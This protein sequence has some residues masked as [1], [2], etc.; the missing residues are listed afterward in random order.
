MIAW[1][2]LCLTPA[3]PNVANWAHG[4]GLAA[5]AAA[6]YLAFAYDRLRKK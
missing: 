1:F 3:L 2:V 6:G 4:V 5:G